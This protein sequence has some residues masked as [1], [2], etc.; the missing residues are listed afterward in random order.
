MKKQELL[1]KLKNENV[2]IIMIVERMDMNVYVDTRIVKYGFQLSIEGNYS[3]VNNYFET[4]NYVKSVNRTL[5]ITH[6]DVDRGCDC[7]D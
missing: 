1:K 7:N 3:D 6:V 4:V 2:N 5:A